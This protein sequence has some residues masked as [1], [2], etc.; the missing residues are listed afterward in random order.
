MS[1]TLIIT[2]TV[3]HVGY[4]AGAGGASIDHISGFQT[5]QQRQAA[6]NQWIASTNPNKVNWMAA[7]A[8]C[9]QVPNSATGKKS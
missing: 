8:V 6:G 9:V 3:I 1:W 5:A 2:P 4:K 7:R